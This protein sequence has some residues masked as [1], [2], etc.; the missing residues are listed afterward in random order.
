M[1]VRLD[2]ALVDILFSL[3]R[4]TYE[5]CLVPAFWTNIVITPAA[6][7]DSTERSSV[8]EQEL[9]SKQEDA[10]NSCTLKPCEGA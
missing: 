4:L 1:R 3:Y 5:R 9:I 6:C 10:L 7:A 8:L 2:S